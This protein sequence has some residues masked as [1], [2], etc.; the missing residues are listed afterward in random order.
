MILFTIL[1]NVLVKIM[2][3]I[4]GE[5]ELAFTT[6]FADAFFEYFIRFEWFDFFVKIVPQFNVLEWG[7][8]LSKSWFATRKSQIC[9]S[10][11]QARL[12][13]WKETRVDRNP[14]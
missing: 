5:K 1:P 2:L 6:D 14:S 12:P 3:A 8:F 13:E 10:I 7:A 11:A 9:F 4:A